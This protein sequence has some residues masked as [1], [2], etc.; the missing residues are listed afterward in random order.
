MP[1]YQPLWA[2]K[3]GLASDGL[4]WGSGCPPCGTHVLSPGP[5]CSISPLQL[6][7][8]Y[9]QTQHYGDNVPAKQRVIFWP[10]SGMLHVPRPQTHLLFGC[11][12]VRVMWKPKT[13]ANFEKKLHP[14]VSTWT[15]GRCSHYWCTALVVEG[16]WF[17]PLVT[18]FITCPTENCFFSTLGA[19][20]A[21][22]QHLWQ[23]MGTKVLQAK[24]TRTVDGSSKRFH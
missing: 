1:C 23:W 22:L 12:V 6:C 19:T 5:G 4:G 21:T 17:N 10:F 3:L 7:S 8:G 24:W 18:N 20:K 9:Q 15:L 14:S 11:C 16:C 13:S 2:F